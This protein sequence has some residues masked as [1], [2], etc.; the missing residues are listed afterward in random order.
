MEEKNVLRASSSQTYV[1]PEKILLAIEKIDGAIQITSDVSL[2]LDNVIHEVMKIFKSD[3]AWLFYPCNPKLSSFEVVLGNRTID[4]DT[5]SRYPELNTGPH[6][7]LCVSDTGDGINPEIVDRVFDP[8]FTTKDVGKGTGLGLSVVHGIVNSHHGRISVESKP[9]KGTTFSILFPALERVTRDE[10]KEFQEL[11]TGKERILF[12]DDEGA[13]VNLNQQ[14]LE[15]LGYTV[16]P[17]TDPLEA[18]DFFHA[19]PDQIDLV[20]TDMTMPRMTG[21]R[22]TQEILNI[23]PDMPIILCTGYSNR[24]SEERAKEIGIRKYIEKPIEM[25]NLARTVRE[26]LDG[27][28]IA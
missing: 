6:V 14:R 2:A 28:N 19:N 18:L 21:D 22:L 5:A 12:V 7:Q 10:P 1:D 13:M 8:Y 4:E 15:R 11:P 27:R 26:V 17:K 24:I 3:R 23:R 25:E 16:V 20:I 9:E